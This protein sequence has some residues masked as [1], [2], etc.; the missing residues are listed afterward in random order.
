MPADCQRLWLLNTF[1]KHWRQNI[2]S[3]WHLG[4]NQREEGFS[5]SLYRKTLPDT[6]SSYDIQPAL[7]DLNILPL[8]KT[9][10]PSPPKRV[11]PAKKTKCPNLGCKN[12]DK[13][14][15]STSQGQSTCKCWVFL[16]FFSFKF[17]IL[18]LPLTLKG[19][20]VLQAYYSTNSK[21]EGA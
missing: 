13:Y 15:T 8:Y 5:V 1:I 6:Q 18:R 10:Y 9:L 4:E 14:G 2:K 20:S 12:I 11:W 21:K 3:K 16:R 17:E 7:S 19:S